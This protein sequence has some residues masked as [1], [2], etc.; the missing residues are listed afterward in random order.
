V[1]HTAFLTTARRVPSREEGGPPP[2]RRKADTG[3][4]VTWNDPVGAEPRDED[5][6]DDR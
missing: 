5:A 2:P 3:A 6:A 4:G 1:A